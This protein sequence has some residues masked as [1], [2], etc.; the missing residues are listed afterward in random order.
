MLQM[1][2]FAASPMTVHDICEVTKAEMVLWISPGSEDR[3][4]PKMIRISRVPWDG[5]WLHDY[6]RESIFKE[7]KLPKRSEEEN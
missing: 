1:A 6:V 4:E 3:R 5:A 7:N 2:T